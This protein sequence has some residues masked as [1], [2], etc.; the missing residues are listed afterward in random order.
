[1]PVTSIINPQMT[2]YKNSEKDKHQL[3][4]VGTSVPDTNFEN[5]MYEK[6]LKQKNFAEELKKQIEER[7]YLRKKEEWRIS[8]ATNFTAAPQ[9]P[10]E[11]Q[12]QTF[13]PNDKTFY[14]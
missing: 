13:Y 7:D 3:A 10:E 12:K 6:E 4:I 11:E 5:K 14:V 1:M 9:A 2:I 8:K